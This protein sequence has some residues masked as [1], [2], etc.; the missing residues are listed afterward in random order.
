MKIKRFSN[1]ICY[2]KLNVGGIILSV[3]SIDAPQVGLD[4]RVNDVFYDELQCTVVKIGDTK[5]LFLCGDFN[6]HIDSTSSGYEGVHGGLGFGEQN[7]DREMILE[8]SVA[9]QPV[10]YN[11]F[12]KERGSHLV[13][14]ES[15]GSST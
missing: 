6:G 15:G 7:T 2:I 8:F 3:L 11:S 14:Y 1:R 9:S 4:D 12:F 13:T 5:N 10:I